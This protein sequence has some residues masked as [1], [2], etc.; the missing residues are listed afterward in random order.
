MSD[1]RVRKQHYK[2]P[3]PRYPST[4]PKSIDAVRVLELRKSWMNWSAIAREL[5]VDIN[6]LRRW[7]KDSKFVDCIHEPD[8]A[9]LDATLRQYLH[10]NPGHGEAVTSAYL[11]SKGWYVKRQVLRNAVARVDP[12]GRKR[13]L[14]A[15]RTSFKED[16][17]KVGREKRKRRKSTSN[18]PISDAC[19]K[20]IGD[21]S[22]ERSIWNE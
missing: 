17:A 15:S 10:Q 2:P 3:P 1:S 4:N 18:A 16:I 11:K 20:E 14:E 8:A 22:S 5:D 9:E 7:K 6:A 12:N 21:A 13:R 19:E